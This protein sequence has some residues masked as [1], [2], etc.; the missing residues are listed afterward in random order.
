MI[1]LV[2]LESG[3]E[4]L[5]PISNIARITTTNSKYELHTVVYLKCG[6][7]FEIRQ[8]IN[9]IIDNTDHDTDH[10]IIHQL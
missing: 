6:Y 4:H 2:E 1:K 7:E 9:T 8:C 5:I 3:K 10:L